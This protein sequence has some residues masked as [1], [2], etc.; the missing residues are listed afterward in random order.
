M[1]GTPRRQKKNIS[2]QCVKH[3]N[4]KINYFLIHVIMI[5][6]GYTVYIAC[7][8]LIQVWQAVQLRLKAQ[9]MKWRPICLGYFLKN[10]IMET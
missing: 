5:E 1:M 10:F 6:V 3:K 2:K 4:I 8:R 9:K 7:G